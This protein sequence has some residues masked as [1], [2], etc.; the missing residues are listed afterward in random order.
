MR[1]ARLVRGVGD[2]VGLAELTRGRDGVLRV[3]PSVLGANG[4]A[5]RHD[6][7]L[8]MVDAAGLEQRRRGR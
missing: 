6:A 8:N 3:L 2:E 7:P 1:P 4:L 5:V